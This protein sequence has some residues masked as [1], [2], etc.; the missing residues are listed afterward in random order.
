VE[1]VHEVGEHAQDGVL[2]I[3]S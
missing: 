3:F 1:Y 2:S